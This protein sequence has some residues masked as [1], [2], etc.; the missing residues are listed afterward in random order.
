MFLSFSF[1]PT[2]NGPVHQVF[3]AGLEVRIEIGPTN[4]QIQVPMN[5]EWVFEYNLI[6]GQGSCLIVQ[7]ISIAPR[8]WM[9]LSFLITTFS[10][11]MIMEPLSQASCDNHWKHFRSQIPLLH[12]GQ[13][14]PLL[15][16]PVCQ[17]IDK[18]DDGHHHHHDRINNQE[19][20]FISR[21]KSGSSSLSI[22]DGLLNSSHHG[23]IP[24]Y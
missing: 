18:E 17:T 24:D 23:F 1:C 16:I 20:V 6:L 11:A 5:I 13:R 22:N 10:L 14:R 21:S 12:W 3:K 19:M 4:R 8:S 15:M 7:R 2:D 9:A